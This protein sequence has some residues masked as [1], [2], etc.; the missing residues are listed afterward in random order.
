M[1][2]GNHRDF[3]ALRTRLTARDV[4]R[5]V[6]ALVLLGALACTEFKPGSDIETNTRTL[7][8]AESPAATASSGGPW[9]CLDTP[10]PRPAARATVS[11]TVTIVD[12]VTNVPPLGLSVRA[13]DDVD[14]TCS[15]P[16]APATGVSADGRVRLSLARGFDGYFDIHADNILPT[17]LYPDGTLQDDQDGATLEL[18]DA[19]SAMGL[20]SAVG[21]DLEADA[22]LVLARGFNCEGDLN[23]G[24][25][26]QSG[27]GGVPFAFI[28]GLPI[29]GDT[30]GAEG[31]VVFA[32]V[33]RGFTLLQGTVAATQKLMGSTT[34]ESVPGAIVYA[35]VRPPPP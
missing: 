27:A 25:E 11:Y 22:G 9:S 32:N 12:S 17:R 23:S 13:C 28:D 15:R 7:L 14:T 5:S 10:P 1:S 16:V 21:L 35:D 33:P 4:S 31:L 26:F 34:A 18:I 8:G 30:T 20:A 19:E 24:I 2:G 6:A 29:A 3:F